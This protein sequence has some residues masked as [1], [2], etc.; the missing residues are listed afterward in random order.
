[1]DLADEVAPADIVTLDRVICCYPDV[2]ALV[3]RSLARA[4]RLYGLVLPVDRWWTRTFARLG[5]VMLRLFRSDWRIHVHAQQVVEQLIDEAGFERRY[6]HT[7]W[8][9]QTLVY[10]RTS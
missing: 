3:T 4:T 8:L 1:V 10:A 9:W 5:N 6:R 2:H 7:G